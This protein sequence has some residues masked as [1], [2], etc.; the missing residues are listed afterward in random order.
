M[1][2]TGDIDFTNW[3]SNATKVIR[4][5]L[6]TI[7]T[8]AGIVLRYTS[9]D[10]DITLPDGRTYVRG[11]GFKRSRLKLSAGLQV[12]QLDVTLLVTAANTIVGI[13]MAYHAR[14]G[15]F[16][17]ATVLLE[18]AYFDELGTY[19]GFVRKFPGTAGPATIEPGQIRFSVRSELAKLQTM[20]PKEVYQ[21]ACLNQPYDTRCAL[22]KATWQVSAAVSA[23][24]GSLVWLQASL[25]QAA[26]YFDLGVLTFTSGANTGVARTVKSFAGGVFQFARPFLALPSVGDTFVVRPGCD[27][28]LAMCVSKF[29]NKPR[30]RA[31]PFT[32]APETVA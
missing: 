22:V 29:N 17:G 14:A 32:P 10:V 30:F 20:L 4:C 9:G 2:D 19:K 11:P 31:H 13:P 28:T 21:P 8:R 24:N 25:G 15:G 27:R 6:W 26:G 18:W 1:I 3:L 7:I 5:D 23:V 16:D 12:D